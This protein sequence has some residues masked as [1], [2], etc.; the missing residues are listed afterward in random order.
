MGLID[1]IPKSIQEN[2]ML[3]CRK[4]KMYKGFYKEDDKW[5][6]C[7]CGLERKDDVK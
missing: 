1:K 6:C 4:C 2:K 5:I 7:K 3:F